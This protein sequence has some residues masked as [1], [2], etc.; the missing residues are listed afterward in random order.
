MTKI[1][2]HWGAFLAAVTFYTR[3]PIPSLWHHRVTKDTLERSAPWLPWL[4]TLIGGCS[5][6][7]FKLAAEP[8]GG[9]LAAILSIS[10]GILMTGAFHED[11]LADMVDGFGGGWTK[12]DILR[13]M[14][15]ST[16]GSYGV[17]AL[18]LAV[19]AKIFALTQMNPAKA[20][21]VILACHSAARSMAI[22]FLATHDYVREEGKAQNATTR[23]PWKAT[24]WGLIPGIL[25]LFLIGWKELLVT[26]GVLLVLRIYLSRLFTKKLGGYTGDCLGASEQLAEVAILITCTYFAS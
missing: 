21:W 8:L 2:A 26:T 23:L 22:T 15:D 11:G 18:I 4:G 7:V 6:L 25:G 20:P 1:S 12:A 9:P 16:H 10:C 5:A 3:I 14:K 13:I 24:F 17:L 19:L